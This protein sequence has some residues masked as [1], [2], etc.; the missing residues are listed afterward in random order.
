MEDEITVEKTEMNN[1]TMK[2][3]KRSERMTLGDYDNEELWKFLKQQGMQ[4]LPVLGIH[5]YY[6]YTIPL[7]ISSVMGVST[8]FEMPLYLVHVKGL[9]E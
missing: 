2:M 1:E 4:L 3:E 5:Y 7:V 9:T 6:Q 8:L